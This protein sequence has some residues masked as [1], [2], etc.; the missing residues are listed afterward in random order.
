MSEHLRPPPG[1]WCG[2]M[3]RTDCHPLG[4]AR[5]S[6]TKGVRPGVPILGGQGKGVSEG[7]NVERRFPFMIGV[8]VRKL[9][10]H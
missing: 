2:V 1:F 6:V 7:V 3:E 9:L 5:Q 4:T 10:L 8:G